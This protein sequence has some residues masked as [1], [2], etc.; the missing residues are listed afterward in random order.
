MGYRC[1]SNTMKQICVYDKYHIWVDPFDYRVNLITKENGTQKE[2]IEIWRHL[3]SKNTDVCL[4]IGANYGEFV[5]T[6]LDIHSNIIAFEP[7]PTVFCCL[8]KTCHNIKN[9]TLINKACS[10]EE[11]S[12]KLLVPLSSG[13]G[14]L[15]LH[16]GKPVD[17]QTTRVSNWIKDKSFVVKIDVEGYEDIILEDLIPHCIKPFYIMFEYN[18]SC[19]PNQKNINKIFQSDFHV[20]FLPNRSSNLKKIESL[21]YTSGEIIISNDNRLID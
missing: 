10:N 17:V 4:D 21:P 6:I 20:W 5:V 12:K 7:N 13:A 1:Y 18:L 11:G 19:S 2:K 3:V 15:V 14:S 16:K 9:V 8:Q